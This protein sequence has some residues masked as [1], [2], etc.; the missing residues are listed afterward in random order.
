MLAFILI[1]INKIMKSFRKLLSNRKFNFST[2]NLKW[3]EDK[4]QDIKV[5]QEQAYI[6]LDSICNHL[7]TSDCGTV[8]PKCKPNFLRHLIEKVPNKTPSNYDDIMNDLDNKLL[9]NF[10]KFTHNGYLSWF[11]CM[12][13]Y[14]GILGHLVG[15]GFSNPA[16]SYQN[17]KVIFE[18]EKKITDWFK[19]AYGL[20]DVFSQKE[21]GALIFH[22]V[23]LTS[24]SA[25]LAAKR[26]ALNKYP[27][28]CSKFRYYCSEQS[29]YSIKKAINIAGS[30]AVIIPIIFDNKK[31][32]FVMDMDLLNKTIEEDVRNGLIP[33]YVAATLGTTGT[34]AIDY[35]EEI[36]DI[37]RKYKMWYHVDAAYAGNAL[38]L[39]EFRWTAKGI[40]KANSFAFNPVKLFPTLQNSACCFYTNISHA[41]SAYEV[42]SLVNQNQLGLNL[43]DAEFGTARLNKALKLYSAFSVL[44]KDYLKDLARRIFNAAKLSEKLL[45]ESGKFEVLFQPCNFALVCF[46]LKTRGNE[47]LIKLITKINDNGKLFIGPMDVKFVDKEELILVRLSINWLYTTDEIITKNMNDIIDCY[48]DTFKD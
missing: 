8:L 32:N 11:P 25:T 12:T 45:S 2:T 4:E 17:S 47:E 37:A 27:N 40:E 42:D 34:T 24:I 15:H 35:L 22:G 18:L 16:T 9:S 1:L 3:G 23:S 36:G 48:N 10:T 31:N 44:G 26:I 43:N 41:V 29:H 46:K 14:P 13:S 33:I 7:L 38:I 30:K 39:E 28:D 21:S 20:P 6:A 19:E 5:F